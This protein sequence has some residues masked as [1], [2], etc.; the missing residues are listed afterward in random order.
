MLFGIDIQGI[1]GSALGGQLL[2]GTLHRATDAAG[3]YGETTKTFVNVSI[4][5]IRAAWSSDP[6]VRNAFAETR[7]YPANAMK[8]TILAAGLGSAPTEND[9]ITMEGVRHRI[10][11]VGSDPATATYTMAA[12]PI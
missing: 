3:A 1:V 2:T 11:G 12:V 7:V 4:E 10:L 5:G 9:E 8:I 6:F